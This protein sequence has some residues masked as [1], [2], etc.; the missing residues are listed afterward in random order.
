MQRRGVAAE[1]WT[2][3][4]EGSSGSNVDIV[5]VHFS[6]LAGVAVRGEA[7]LA[8]CWSGKRR[9]YTLTQRSSFEHALVLL[10]EG[11]DGAISCELRSVVESID[12]GDVAGVYGVFEET[13]DV[14]L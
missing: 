12:I 8:S 14:G 2:F 3:G 1:E 6:N 4:A 7:W 5:V 13:D 10:L 11:G 9:A